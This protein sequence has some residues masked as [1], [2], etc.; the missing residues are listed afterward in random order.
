MRRVTFEL[1]DT[2][3][4]SPADPLV[5]FVADADIQFHAADEKTLIFRFTAMGTAIKGGQSFV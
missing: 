2:F 1:L 4:D 5:A 3:Q